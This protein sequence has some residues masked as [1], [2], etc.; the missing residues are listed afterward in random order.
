MEESHI[1]VVR[2]LAAKDGSL[3]TG[4]TNLHSLE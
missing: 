1:Q 3:E 2:N 4:R